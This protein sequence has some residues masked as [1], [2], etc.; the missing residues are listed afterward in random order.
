MTET[1]EVY[2]QRRQAVADKILAEPEHFNMAAYV[3]GGGQ[4][5][6]DPMCG[7]TLCIAGWAAL[8]IPDAILV[9]RLDGSPRIKSQNTFL[10]IHRAAK[11]WLGLTEDAA[12][13]LFYGWF[14]KGYGIRESDERTQLD[15][16]T[17]AEAVAALL[18]A[19][20]ICD[21]E[22]GES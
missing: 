6:A 8:Q 21:E 13:W 22:G 2:E 18:A 17:P 10:G 7:T 1:R 12:D 9:R 4:P 16:I 15:E 14:R 20:Y 11:A 19:P 5:D 3:E